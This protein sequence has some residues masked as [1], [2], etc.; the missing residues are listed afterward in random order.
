MSGWRRY[1][2]AQAAASL[3]KAQAGLH[4]IPQGAFLHNQV[5]EQLRE[6]GAWAPPSVVLR[7]C[8][9]AHSIERS[10]HHAIRAEACRR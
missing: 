4:L 10:V 7:L 8:W 2:L 3:N 1:L 9:C 6:T 5:R